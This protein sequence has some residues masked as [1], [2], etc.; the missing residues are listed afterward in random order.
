MPA[1]KFSPSELCRCGITTI[2]SGPTSRIISSAS[3]RLCQ[4]YG[5]ASASRTTM[6]NV[7]RA[8][9]S[10]LFAS[11][12]TGSQ[13]GAVNRFASH[14]FQK[15]TSASDG[16]ARRLRGRTT[17]AVEVSRAAAEVEHAAAT[18]PRGAGRRLQQRL[19][20]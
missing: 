15:Y 5:N 17:H 4:M 13:P 2:P 14:S 12:Q 8:N 19:R 11:Q 9:G 10:G 7:S 18:R 1:E 3:S 6:E 16:A 20:S